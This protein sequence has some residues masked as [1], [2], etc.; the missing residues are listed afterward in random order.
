[1]QK[2]IISLLIL[3]VLGLSA[4]LVRVQDRERRMEERLAAAEHFRPARA[5]APLPSTPEEPRAVSAAEPPPPASK[6]ATH[7]PGG[8]EA[9]VEVDPTPASPSIKMTYFSGSRNLSPALRLTDAQRRAILDLRRSADLQTQA[10]RDLEQQIETQT[11]DAI[12]R[13]LDP[14]QLQVYDAMA[15]TPGYQLLSVPREEPPPSD[16]R[17]GYLGVTGADANGGGVQLTSVQPGT[18]AE[19]SGLRTGDVILEVNGEKVGNYNDLAALVRKNGE[20]GPVTLRIR[21]GASEFY[22]GVQLGQRP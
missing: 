13:L 14:Q 10:Y 19:S 9:K 7:R 12:R 18:V 1:M 8:P 17:P 11:E 15:V 21:R 20:G 5:V 22:Q 4:A 6:T 2:T 3:L 16:R